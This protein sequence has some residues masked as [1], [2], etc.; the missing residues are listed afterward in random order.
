MQRLDHLLKVAMLSREGRARLCP[1]P[2]TLLIR[3][4]CA[5]GLAEGLSVGAA[6]SVAPAHGHKRR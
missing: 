1:T 4:Y 2:F 5:E 3:A 6:V